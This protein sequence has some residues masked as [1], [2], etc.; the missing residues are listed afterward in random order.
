VRGMSRQWSSPSLVDSSSKQQFWLGEKHKVRVSPLLL[1]RTPI[2]DFDIV[3]EK[4]VS[5][6]EIKKARPLL[7]GL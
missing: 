6:G 7:T 1:R 3:H 5:F 2:Q 4:L